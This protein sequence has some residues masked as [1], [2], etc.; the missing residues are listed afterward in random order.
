MYVGDGVTTYL[1]KVTKE[2]IFL[3]FHTVLEIIF[4]SGGD[5]DGYIVSEHWK[6]LAVLFEE[7][8]KDDTVFVPYRYEQDGVIELV[9]GQQSI[10]FVRD[11]S[12]V[13]TTW[14]SDIV[15]EI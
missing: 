1:D 12:L 10:S 15:V 3:L 14:K 7:F 11:R 9:D 8:V 5:G 2:R 6:K 4:D 13:N